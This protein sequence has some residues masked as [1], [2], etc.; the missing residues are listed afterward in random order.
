[1]FINWKIITYRREGFIIYIIY[2]SKV[3]GELHKLKGIKVDSVGA[4]SNNRFYS[5]HGH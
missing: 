3:D 4:H 2:R 5:C 1:M